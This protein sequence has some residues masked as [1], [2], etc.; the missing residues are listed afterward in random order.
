[1]QDHEAM[2]LSCAGFHTQHQAI[3]TTP[4]KNRTVRQDFVIVSIPS[5][6][7][8]WAKKNLE[9]GKMQPPERYNPFQYLHEYLPLP[10]DVLYS[11]ILA[12]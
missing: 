2:T 9:L 5:V 7:E 1:M 11:C 3:V 12:E 10:L 4:V 6:R 8:K